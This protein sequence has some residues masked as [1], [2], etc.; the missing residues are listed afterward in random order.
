MAPNVYLLL[1]L[2]HHPI[3]LLTSLRSEGK[4]GG[5]GGEGAVGWEGVSLLVACKTA[6]LGL[7]LGTEA[8]LCYDTRWQA[9]LLSSYDLQL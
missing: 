7:L 3:A 1:G 4:P 2:H 8:P 9:P 5:G 6:T